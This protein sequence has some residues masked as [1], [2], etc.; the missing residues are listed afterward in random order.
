MVES[1]TLSLN[2]GFIYDNDTSCVTRVNHQAVEEIESGPTFI[3]I[4]CA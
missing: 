4:C 1:E 3:C 2:V